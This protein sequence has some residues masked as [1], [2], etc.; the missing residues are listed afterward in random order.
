M[1][2]MAAKPESPEA[3]LTLL[4]TAVGSPEAGFRPHQWDAITG[5]LRRERLLLVQRTGWGKSIVYFLATR[6]LR[7]GGAGCT[8]LISPLLALMRNQIEA[9]RRIGV[10]AATINSSN[11]ED[12]PPILKDLRENRVDV[13]LISPERLAND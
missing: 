13:L 8:L 7:E 6:L 12:W 9:A 10:R 2:T 3:A 5:L 4:R 1:S 11:I